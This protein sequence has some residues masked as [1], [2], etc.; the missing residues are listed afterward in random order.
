MKKKI[1]IGVMVIFILANL[2]GCKKETK[3][4]GAV[5]A[6]KFK[7]EYESL[8][9]TE[10]SSGKTHR[11]ITIA[12]DNPFIYT[13]A[14]DIV[15]RIENGETFY[16]Y[17]GSKLCPWCRSV[18]E[19]AI[20]MAKENNIEIIYYVDIWDNDGNEILRDQYSLEENELVKKVNGTEAYYKLLASFDELLTEYTFTD[21][22]GKIIS[23]NEKRLYAPTFFYIREGKAQKITTGISE[24]QTDSR[25][26]L[27]E[28]MINEEKELFTK[29]FQN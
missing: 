26:N 2:T 20:E 25:M 12:S 14:E 21:D 23:T 7:E 6:T 15:N 22:N 9:G 29:F 1:L 19:M 13:S 24:L 4:E 11:T 17:F 5:D 10:N 18:I 16:V 8:N 3:I 28:E 27:T